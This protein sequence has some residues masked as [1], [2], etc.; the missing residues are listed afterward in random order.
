MIKYSTSLQNISQER[1][2]GF[3]VGWSSPPSPETHLRILKGGYKVVIAIDDTS[4]QIIGFINAISDGVLS[5]YIS[6][7]EVLPDYQG[8]GIGQELVGLM[9]EELKDL[10]MI[11]LLCDKELQ[12][13]YKKVGMYEAFG[14]SIRNYEHQ[15]G[16]KI[17]K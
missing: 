5:A 7:L 13:F 12:G 6:L 11:D 2:K 3:F 10:Y 16:R 15:S 4:N 1:L 8:Q 9:L 14:M 17:Q